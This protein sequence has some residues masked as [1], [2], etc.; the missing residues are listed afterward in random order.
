MLS[1]VLYLVRSFKV[2]FKP[3][4]TFYKNVCLVFNTN[5]LFTLPREGNRRRRLEIAKRQNNAHGIVT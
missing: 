4:T 2:V 5:R 3:S 1:M